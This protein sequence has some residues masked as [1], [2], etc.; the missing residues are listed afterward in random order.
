MHDDTLKLKLHEIGAIKFGNFTLKSG[1]SSPI[2]VDLRLVVSYP[3]LLADLAEVMWQKINR[4]HFDLLCGVPY[5]ALPIATAM[6]LAH[7]KP[8]IM[9]RK[10]IKNHGTKKAVEGLYEPGQICMVVEDLVT[11]GTS[12][13]E[14]FGSL[15]QE[16]L[17]VRDVVALI[18]R[19]Q[20]GRSNL[21]EEGVNLHS[22]FTLT[23]FLET[24]SQ[25][26]KIDRKTVNTV[27]EFIAQ[28]QVTPVMP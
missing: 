1:I 21:K 17:V 11:S 9:R 23:E 24:L 8:M 4:V 13:L 12:V 19:E 10:E 18:D 22:A 7:T 15:K 20:G 14:T 16:G 5:T 25:A 28:N 2:Y 27:K 26:G 6:S 3:T